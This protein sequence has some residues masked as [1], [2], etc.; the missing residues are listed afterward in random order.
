[1]RPQVGSAPPMPLPRVPRSGG[2]AEAAAQQGRC[3]A[4]WVCGVNGGSGA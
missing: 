3:A 1:M 2:A 4:G